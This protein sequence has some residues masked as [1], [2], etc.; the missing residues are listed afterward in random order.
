MK[1]LL[2][3]SKK[4]P[5]VV[6]HLGMPRDSSATPR[7]ASGL[8]APEDARASSIKGEPGARSVGIMNIPLT[9]VY[10]HISLEIFNLLKLVSSESSYGNPK[11]SKRRMDPGIGGN[12]NQQQQ[13]SGVQSA[14][15]VQVSCNFRLSSVNV[16]WVVMMLQDYL[17]NI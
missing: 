14:S 11:A 3:E 2:C 6:G 7:C 4:D 12:Q 9:L 10:C 5:A 1:C 13:R 15:S 8:L 16:A 17:M